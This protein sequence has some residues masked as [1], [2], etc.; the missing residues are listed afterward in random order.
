MRPAHSSLQQRADI[1]MASSVVYTG[2]WRVENNFSHSSRVSNPSTCHP[3]PGQNATWHRRE[4]GWLSTTISGFSVRALLGSVC[5]KFALLWLLM[6]TKVG[7]FPL[8]NNSEGQRV[9]TQT[10]GVFIT[11]RDFLTW[12]CP[13]IVASTPL[14]L[15]EPVSDCL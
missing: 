6:K 13:K 15:P 12:V 10:D 3:H 8:L 11:E 4:R 2:R 1:L 7:F 14:C 9:S 5:F